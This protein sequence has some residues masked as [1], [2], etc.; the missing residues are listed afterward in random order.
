[1]IP[2]LITSSVIRVGEG[3]GFV[4]QGERE[5]LV[6]TAAHCLPFFPPCM[7]TS[8]TE[9]RTHKCLLGSIGGKPSVWTECLFADPIA[10]IAVL[11]PLDSQVLSDQWEE[12]Q[13]LVDPLPPV[14]IADAPGSQFPA[15]LLSLDK[16]WHPCTV[17][18][19]G[20]P[21]WVWQAENGIDGGMSGSPILLGDGSAVGIVGTATLN[22][23]IPTQG[24]P[25]PTEAQLARLVLA[26]VGAEPNITSDGRSVP[27]AARRVLTPRI[28]L[29]LGTQHRSVIASY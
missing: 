23:G 28:D 21:L 18:Q 13:D 29:C 27:N 2:E 12:Y 19:D 1:M 14:K 10:D 9:D 15:W 11:G 5:K 4:V 25:S 16:Q 22:E 6:L 8:A 7:T 26:D 20:G 24:A 17:T 3:R